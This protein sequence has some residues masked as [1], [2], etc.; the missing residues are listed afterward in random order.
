ME[1]YWS[2]SIYN[3]KYQKWHQCSRKWMLW[4]LRHYIWV[5]FESHKMF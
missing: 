1:E 4:F 5:L 3:W 2:F